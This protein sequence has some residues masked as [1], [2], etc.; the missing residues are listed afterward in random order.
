MDRCAYRLSGAS[1]SQTMLTQDLSSSRQ[2]KRPLGSIFAV[3]VLGPLVLQI[4]LAQLNISDGCSEFTANVFS[5]TVALACWFFAGSLCFAPILGKRVFLL[6]TVLVLV[7]LCA[8]YTHFYLIFAPLANIGSSNELAHADFTGDLGVQYNAALVF[9]DTLRTEGWLYA[10][11]GD[12]YRA[13]NNPGV[14]IVFGTLMSS[15]GEYGTVAI[16]WLVVYSGFSALMFGLVARGMGLG[17]KLSTRVIVLVF[18]MPVFYISPPLYR[19]IFIIFLLGLTAYTAL[20][21]RSSSVLMIAP[22]L[23]GESLLLFSLRLVYLLL[24]AAYASIALFLNTPLN[25][26]V[27]SRW[28][29]FAILGAVVVT[30][31]WGFIG[32]EFTHFLDR[33][34]D[35][36]ESD[37]A[38][39]SILAPFKA[40]GPLAF[41]PAASVFA[42][43]APM[44]WWQ[45]IEPSLLSYQVFSYAQ[46]WYGLT[47]II[48]TYRSWKRRLLPEGGSLMITYYLIIFY[49]AIFGSLNFGFGY[50][51][52]ALPF[53]IVASIR[54]L[55]RNWVYC[56]KIST[57]IVTGTHLFLWA[58]Q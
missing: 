2:S 46:T 14:S 28:L 35:A 36:L 20:E 27:A 5:I 12:Y 13:I 52:I 11:F 26:R 17:A 48:A 55:S 45:P 34:G 57:L 29:V 37:Q 42:V 24:P 47:I 25:W 3:T 10:L 30:A 49:L 39:F 16:P 44:P 8:N 19:D 1:G 33:S 31:G 53:L 6:L 15:F 22:F 50:F 56:L 7:R 23:I 21:L 54:Y 18:M 38:A 40:M 4:V 32:N 51:Q 43:L 9:V 58:R 41:Y